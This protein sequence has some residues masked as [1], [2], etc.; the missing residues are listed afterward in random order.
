MPPTRKCPSFASCFQV[1]PEQDSRTCGNCQ[2]FLE[3]C[4][5][6]LARLRRGPAARLILN[7]INEKGTTAIRATL[8]LRRAR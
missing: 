8:R 4:Q 5:L 7:P 2:K 6:P 3:N 1:N